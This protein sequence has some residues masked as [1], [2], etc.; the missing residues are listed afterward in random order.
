MNTRCFL[1]FTVL[2]STAAAQIPAPAPAPASPLPGAPLTASGQ[3]GTNFRPDVYVNQKGTTPPGSRW[4]AH[5]SVQSANSDTPFTVEAM[6]VERTAPGRATLRLALTNNGSGLLEAAGQF[7]AG[8]S[9]PAGS[10]KISGV[11]LF[12]P[13]T[14]LRLDGVGQTQTE[15]LCTK[16]E[17]LL[18]PGERRLLEAEYPAPADGV[19]SVYVYFPHA[20]PIA[21]VPVTP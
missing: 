14:K 5:G 12:D 19:T 7:A 2:V 3:P 9:D 17:A 16:F 6:S 15:A 11:Y 4:V 1:A 21:D 10:Q 13:K 8:L 18:Q 20:A